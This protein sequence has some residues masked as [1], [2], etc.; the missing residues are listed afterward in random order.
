MLSAVRALSSSLR[1]LPRWTRTSALA[2]LALYPAGAAFLLL[3]DDGWAVNR[4]NVRVWYAVT[5]VTGGRDVITPEVFAVI[6]NVALFVPVFAALAV[7]VPTRWWVLL[8]ALL[9]TA[10]ELHQMGIQREAD[11]GD[12]VANTFGAGLG[13]VLGIGLRALVLRR[14]AAPA[15]ALP[16]EG[17]RPDGAALSDG[18]ALGAGVPT[19]RGA[20][21]PGPAGGPDGGPDDRG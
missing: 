8:A 9:S 20:A 5:A 13:T 18:G 11:L 4:A 10:V 1:A 3:L 14:G 2:V 21:R 19:T 17:I 16:D 15:A 12:V 7:L 6:A